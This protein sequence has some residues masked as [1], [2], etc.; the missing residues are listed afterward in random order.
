[1]EDTNKI[2]TQTNTNPTIHKKQKQNT[3][4]TQVPF[5]QKWCRSQVRHGGKKTWNNLPHSVSSQSCPWMWWC[6]Q[7]F[8]VGRVVVKFSLQMPFRFPSYSYFQLLLPCWFFSKKY[9]SFHFMK[10]RSIDSVC[11]VPMRKKTSNCL[12]K[13]PAERSSV[14]E[15]KRRNETKYMCKWPKQN[16]NVIATRRIFQFIHRVNRPLQKLRVRAASKQRRITPFYLQSGKRTNGF[17]DFFK[18]RWPRH[19]SRVGPKQSAW[20]VNPSCIFCMSFDMSK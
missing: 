6:G 11:G 18:H 15:A 7:K 9:E 12:G 3:N 14:R 10:H 5:S 17:T 19:D 2:P 1:M 13:A 8:L 16:R 4:K 20:N